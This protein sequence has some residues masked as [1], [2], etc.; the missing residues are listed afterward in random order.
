MMFSWIS[1][2][3]P[4]INSA[5]RCRYGWTTAGSES[6]TMAVCPVSRR[7]ASNVRRSK[8]FIAT[9][10]MLDAGPDGCPSS[11]RMVSRTPSARMALV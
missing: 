6:V 7:V 9:L 5:G 11:S 2:V 3:P 4:P 10:A 8:T 1:L